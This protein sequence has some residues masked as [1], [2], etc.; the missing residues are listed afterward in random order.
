MSRAK[1]TT[2]IDAPLPF[3]I[4][5]VAF[6]FE[7]KPGVFKR[8]LVIAISPNR[9]ED[10][11][12]VLTVKVTSHAPRAGFPGEILLNDWAKEGL[13]KPSVARCSKLAQIPLA[14]MREGH[15]YGRLS[16]SD[17]RR[18]CRALKELGVLAAF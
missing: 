10:S 16:N 7:D 5:Q 8:R 14:R 6:E 4:R 9:F 2:S 18:V 15:L 12:L 3:G 1:M 13:P 11:V 17:A